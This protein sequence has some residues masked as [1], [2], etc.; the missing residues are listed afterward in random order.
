MKKII[1]FLIIL[2]GVLSYL[3]FLRP[4]Q[5]IPEGQVYR[6]AFGVKIKTLDP[7]GAGDLYSHIVISQIYEGLLQ[8][9]YLARPYKLIPCLAEDMP[10]VSPDGLIYTFKIKKGVR[11]QDDPCFKATGGKGR[12]LVAEDFVYSFK[13]LADIK[14]RAEGWWTLDGMIKGLN[15]FREHSKKSKVTDYSLPVEGL[16]APDE[17]TLRI[18]LTR[19]YPQFLYV[20]AMSFTMAVPREAVEE[21]GEEIISHPVGTGPFMLKSWRRGS[22]L[23]LVRNP[24]FREEYYPTEGEE[25]DEEAGLLVDAGKRLPFLERIEFPIIIEDQPYWLNFMKGNLDVAG[26]PKD[27]FEQ[28]I[29]PNMELRPEMV[30]KG[31]ILTKTPLPDVTYIGFNMEDSLVGKNKL[32]RQAMS[33]A[34]NVKEVIKLFY[35]GR[36][37]PAQGPIP[38]DIP[39]YDPELVNPYRQ[40][41]L[42]RARELL[43]KAGYP[44]GEGL[45]PLVYENA[46]T[47]TT[48]RQMAEFFVKQMAK[49]GIKI[50]VNNNTWPQFL[51]KI[52]T[53]SAQ[54][55]GLAW[56]ADY[57]DAENFLQLFY[58]PNQA[59]G[60]NNT[61]F[62]HPEYN[63]LYEKVKYMAD[64][65]ER[66]KLIKE[67]VAILIEECPWI[68]GTHRIGFGLRYAWVKNRK[69]H[70]FSHSLK[71]TSIDSELR[72]KLLS[73]R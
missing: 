35:N 7:I 41:N 33:L 64:S 54:V 67:M 44:N 73:K 4:K 5:R 52:K 58:G 49:I 72:K 25:G 17:R 29:N 60:P 23:I 2:I 8:Y 30:K 66:R 69:P 43:A 53:K 32:L 48:A 55:F 61:N 40:Y 59:P 65:P 38:P 39:G 22:K 14:N 31:I 57:P 18:T 10:E 42:E 68:F 12:E 16:E 1:I 24:N 47:D 70:H 71:Y 56:I 13:R 62:N 19:P 37:I 45:P 36:A 50:K 11:F 27:S 63:K 28:A 9:D 51:E 34:Y 46:S 20:L 15:E 21:Y 6:A 3:I 26:I